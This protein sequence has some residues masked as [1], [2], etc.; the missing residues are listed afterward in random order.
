MPCYAMQVWSAAQKQ[1]KPCVTHPLISHTP[2][3]PT[4]NPALQAPFPVLA[5]SSFGVRGA[6]LPAVLRGCVAAGWFGINTWLGGLAIHQ[7]LQTLMGGTLGGSAVVAWLGITAAQ[8][9]CFAAFWAMQVQQRGGLL[10]PRA[11]S[12]ASSLFG[13]LTPSALP[14]ALLTPAAAYA[15]GHCRLPACRWSFC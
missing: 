12:D 10:R 5:R 14:P 15:A 13:A 2:P 11:S 6:V 4:P 8:A 7:M 3:H 1:L 9:W